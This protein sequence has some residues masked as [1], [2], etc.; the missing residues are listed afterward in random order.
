METSVEDTASWEGCSFD[1]GMLA[2][3]FVLVTL[4]HCCS[5]FTRTTGLNIIV[6]DNII[7]TRGCINLH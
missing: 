5:D 7:F 1:A 2:D 6:P 3:L 4:P